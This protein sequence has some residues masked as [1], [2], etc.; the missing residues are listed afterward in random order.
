MSPPLLW[1]LVGIGFFA[2]E[3][4]TPGLVLLFFGIGAWVAASAALIGVAINVQIGVFIVVS[5]IALVVLR[6]K[7]R[8][9]FSGG[10]RNAGQGAESG[11]SHPMLGRHG[12]VS[13][14]L[15]PGS[16][17]EI[18]IGG[19]FWRA[20]SE[21]PLDEG[22]AVVVRATLRGDALVLLVAPEGE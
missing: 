11:A 7:V 17:G 10:D 18:N 2:A 6:R 21:V 5:V 12:T 14:A 19:S 1:F 3:L 4:M 20:Q 8:G 13:Q 9:I 15:V 22:R 16:V